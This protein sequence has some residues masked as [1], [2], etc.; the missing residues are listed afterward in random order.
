MKK[1][2]FMIT[3]MVICQL[4]FAAGLYI[5][6]YTI[7]EVLYESTSW[8]ISDSMYM[9]CMPAL[10]DALYWI[11]RAYKALAKKLKEV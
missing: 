11:I 5:V 8:T 1:K 7:N 9:G 10:I 2:I 6:G 3:V 4:A